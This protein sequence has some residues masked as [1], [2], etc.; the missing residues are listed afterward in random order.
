MD[1]SPGLGVASVQAI[2]S[3]DRVLIPVICEPAILKDLPSDE[4]T[5]ERVPKDLDWSQIE[6]LGE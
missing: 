6:N 5:L 1:C 4:I 2:L 3:S